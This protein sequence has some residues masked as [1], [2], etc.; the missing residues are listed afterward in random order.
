MQIKL[1]PAEIF[2]GVGVEFSIVDEEILWFYVTD[3]GS[4]LHLRGRP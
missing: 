4:Q 3:H 1:I 2:F